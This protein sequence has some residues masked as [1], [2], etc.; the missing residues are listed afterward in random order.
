MMT[1]ES[2]K[3]DKDFFVALD[4]IVS[5]IDADIYAGEPSVVTLNPEP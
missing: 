3:S 2:R 5:K 1:F 4:Q